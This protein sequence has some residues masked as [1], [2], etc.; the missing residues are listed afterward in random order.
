MSKQD[1]KL[2]KYLNK[3]TTE[4][5]KKL[6]LMLKPYRLTTSQYGVL[7]A[8]YKEEKLTIGKVQQEIDSTCGTMPLI[9]NN[10]IKNDLIVKGQDELDKRKFY[11]SITENGKTLYEKLST[12]YELCLEESFS[13]YSKEEQKKLIK[14]LKQFG[15]VSDKKN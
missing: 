9:I 13:V 6:N 15:E 4:L 2:V 8:L 11:L 3:V 1:Y 5:D 7:R 14:L 12:L 10:L